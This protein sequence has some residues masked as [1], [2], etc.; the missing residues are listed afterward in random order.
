[1]TTQIALKC[2]DIGGRFS[3]GPIY[4]GGAT[5]NISG[6]SGPKNGAVN[7]THLSS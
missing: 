1:M 4:G 5:T 2:V 3:G 6:P 7:S